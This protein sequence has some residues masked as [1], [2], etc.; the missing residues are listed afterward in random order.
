MRMMYTSSQSASRD[1]VA[2]PSLCSGGVTRSPDAVQIRYASRVDKVCHRR[3]WILIDNTC[4]AVR[5]PLLRS[6]IDLKGHSKYF[7][8]S[9]KKMRW[10]PVSKSR[11][12][13]LRDDFVDGISSCLVH[14]ALCHST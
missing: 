2:I 8:F 14:S 1:V 5:L 6:Q 11:T 7:D 12:E 3:G 10:A 4:A 13:T 9:N